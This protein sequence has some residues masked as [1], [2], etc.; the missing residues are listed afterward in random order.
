MSLNAG[1]EHGHV[2]Y[3][4]GDVT[5]AFSRLQ[6]T[7]QMVEPGC[8]QRHEAGQL[9]AVVQECREHQGRSCTSEGPQECHESPVQY[10]HVQV[11]YGIYAT[12]CFL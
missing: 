1:N 4:R 7:V 6:I 9:R 12:E 8:W 10:C 2:T 11:E 5:S 3:V